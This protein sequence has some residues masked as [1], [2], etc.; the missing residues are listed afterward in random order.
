[1]KLIPQWKKWWKRHS[2]QLLALIP[3]IEAFRQWLPTVR[4]FISPE[5]YG[6]TAIGLSLTA[7]IVMQIQQKS[8][9][10]GNQNGN[11]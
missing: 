2:V 9:S 4:E 6:W 7:I 8:L 1:M 5:V 3:I 10:E 11:Q